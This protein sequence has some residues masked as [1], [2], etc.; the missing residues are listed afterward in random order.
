MVGSS[1]LST[2]AIKIEMKIIA[3]VKSSFEELVNKVSWPSWEQLQNSAV[4]VAI[5]SLIIALIVFGMDK[6]FGEIVTIILP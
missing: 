5:S 3:Y 4:V 1:N 6:V 2:R